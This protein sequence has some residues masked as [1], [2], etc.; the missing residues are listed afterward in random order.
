MT[1]WLGPEIVRIM[2]AGSLSEGYQADN[3]F[4]IEKTLSSDEITGGKDLHGLEGNPSTTISG[5]CPVC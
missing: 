4:L 5:D 1:M 3:G 2:A